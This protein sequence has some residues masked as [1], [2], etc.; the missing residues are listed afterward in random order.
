MESSVGLEGINALA[1]CLQSIGNLNRLKIVRFCSEKPRRFS[2]II[3]DLKLN[4]ASFKF[5]SKVLMECDLIQKVKRGLY[6]TTELGNI[7][8]DLVNQANKLSK[9]ND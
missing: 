9:D 7:L 1:E 3:F 6:Q 8:L 5:H 4:P 2:D